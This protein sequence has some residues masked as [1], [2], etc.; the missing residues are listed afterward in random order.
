MIRLSS[1]L[2]CLAGILSGEPD[3]I[4]IRIDSQDSFESIPERLHTELNRH[5]KELVFQFDRGTYYFDERML[6]LDGMHFP[7]TSL[8]FVGNGA[9]LTAKGKDYSNGDYFDSVLDSGTG[10][11]SGTKDVFVWSDIYFSDSRVKAV[12]GGLHLYCLKCKSLKKD[13]VCDLSQCY[14][15]LTEWYKSRMMKVHSIEDGSIVF[16]FFGIFYFGSINSNMC[17]F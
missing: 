16:I 10:V 12:D 17:N 6:C 13:M 15:L 11:T 1:I 4:T 14:I 8:R 7:E 3:I 2:L 5:P 9:T